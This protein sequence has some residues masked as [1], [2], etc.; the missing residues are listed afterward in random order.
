MAEAKNINQYKGVKGDV[1]L[2]V[3]KN[4]RTCV[5]VCVCVCVRAHKKGTSMKSQL[6]KKKKERKSREVFAEGK[7]KSRVEKEDHSEEEESVNFTLSM[8]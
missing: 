2:V 5:C 3:K 6:F 4:A 8:R 7:R 1:F